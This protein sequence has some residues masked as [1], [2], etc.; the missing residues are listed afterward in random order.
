M[1]NLVDDI[2][3]QRELTKTPTGTVSP[4]I[5]SW[6]PLHAEQ[7]YSLGYKPTDINLGG[8]WRDF[9]RTQLYS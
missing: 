3:E 1:L 4:G 7:P 8:S 9:L 6:K 5:Y 2:K